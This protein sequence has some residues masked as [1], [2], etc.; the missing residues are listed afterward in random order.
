[1][2]I[3]SL[4]GY[5]TPKIHS[6]IAGE[7]LSS[8]QYCFVKAGASVNTVEHM[9]AVSDEPI[10]ILMNA[11]VSGQ[12]AEVAM[13]GGGAKLKC[14][15][16]VTNGAKITTTAAGLGSLASLGE[17]AYAKA[18]PMGS[19]TAS[20]DVIPVILLG[21]SETMSQAAVVTAIGTTTVLSTTTLADA[22]G[23]VEVRVD[24]IEAKI[25][26]ILAS[27]KATGLMA[28]A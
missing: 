28:S 7:D 13:I 21:I 20:S 16:S 6:M 18:I 19:T 22:I 24:A 5:P 25:D 23:D 17:K 8:Y 9:D 2:T 11:P 1:M 15:N 27:I 12:E 3:T 26:A 4:V 10:G 14:D